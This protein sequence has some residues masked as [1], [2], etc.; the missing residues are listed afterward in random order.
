MQTQIPC[1]VMRGGS[2]KGLY[3]LARD[4]PSDATL[5]DQV[6]VAA[7]GSDAR[8]IDGMGGAEPLTSKVA[9]VSKSSRADADI[10]YLF[11]QVVVGEGRV[12]ISPNCGN[13]LAGTGPFAIEQGIVPVTGDT[14]AVR[15]H[16]VNSGNL[17]ELVIQTPDGAV[18]YEGDTAISGVPGTAAPIIC[19]YLD[20]AG[21]ACGSLYPTG[22]QRD[23]VAGIAPEGFQRP[24][25]K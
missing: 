16:M 2:S 23:M 20:I 1:S 13:I 4:L 22:N 24:Y 14:T 19:N 9:V 17:C 25:R 10:D 12:D 3:F 5:R 6:L 18:Q 11:A 15:V 21:S 7:M 8:Q